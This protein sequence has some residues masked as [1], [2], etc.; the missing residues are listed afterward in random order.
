MGCY[1]IRLC[2]DSL[3]FWHGFGRVL[4]VTRVHRGVCCTICLKYLRDLTGDS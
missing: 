1:T 4:V 2:N 3:G